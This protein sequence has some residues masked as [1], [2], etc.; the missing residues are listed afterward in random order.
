MSYF[1]KEINKS[2]LDESF[3][4]KFSEIIYN[5]F[6]ELINEPVNHNKNGIEKLLLNDKMYGILVIMENKIIGYII[7]EF[8]SL[9]ID[10]DVFY[11]DYIYINNKY[12]KN[13]IGSKLMIKVIEYCKNKV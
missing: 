6:I 10:R 9:D 5:N 7:G 3:I 4:N 8:M 13:G 12:Q 2:S 1:L 11:I